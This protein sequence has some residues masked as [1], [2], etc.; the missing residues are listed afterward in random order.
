MGNNSMQK[1][2]L[3]EERQETGKH[4]DDDEPVQK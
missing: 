3:F 4:D 2:I 1:Q